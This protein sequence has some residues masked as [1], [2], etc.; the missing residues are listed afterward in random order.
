LVILLSNKNIFTLFLSL[1]EK[2]ILAAT[3]SKISSIPHFVLQQNSLY[4]ALLALPLH[5][6]SSQEGI[7]IRLKNLLASARRRRGSIQNLLDEMREIIFQ[8]LQSQISI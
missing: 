1:W 4:K 2:I 3:E 8:L 7:Q 5:E 6:N